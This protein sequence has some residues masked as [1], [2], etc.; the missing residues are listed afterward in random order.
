MSNLCHSYIKDNGLLSLLYS[1]LIFEIYLRYI[2]D[3]N[4]W[5]VGGWGEGWN[6][7]FFVCSL[8]LS[9]N[10]LYLTNI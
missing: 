9:I 10:F 1:C 4:K 7:D 5:E 3:K 2:G 8:I 6:V